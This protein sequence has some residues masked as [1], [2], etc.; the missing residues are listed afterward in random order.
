MSRWFALTRLITVHR[1]A[2]NEYTGGRGGPGAGFRG[3]GGSWEL[4]EVVK[5]PTAAK[6]TKIPP[7]LQKPVPGPPGPPLYS[8]LAPPCAIIDR[9]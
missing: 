2:R 1:G 3:P 4:I 8:L 7:G 6:T 9:L 5:G